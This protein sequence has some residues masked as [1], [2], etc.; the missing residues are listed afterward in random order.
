MVGR[1]QGIK[2]ERCSNESTRLPPM[3]PGFNF[4]SHMWVEFVV[5]AVKMPFYCSLVNA[6]ISNQTLLKTTCGYCC[7]YLRLGGQTVKYLCLLADKFEL[8]QSKR[9]SSQAIA[10]TRKCPKGS[11]KLFLLTKCLL[12]LRKT[13]VIM[14]K[15]KHVCWATCLVYTYAFEKLLTLRIGQLVHTAL[16]RLTLYQIGRDSF[17]L[18]RK[19]ILLYRGRFKQ[20]NFTENDRLS[21]GS[22]KRNLQACAQTSPIPMLYAEKGRLRNAVFPRE[23]RWRKGK[24]RLDVCT[25]AIACKRLWV[26]ISSLKAI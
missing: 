16:T 7:V 17:S 14:T 25:P 2:Q 21:A 12:F 13:A 9:K 3:W 11:W 23:K 1:N 8:D 19:N 22:V 5:A 15:Q 10:S 20:V 26:C 4:R 24:R 18:D 6:M